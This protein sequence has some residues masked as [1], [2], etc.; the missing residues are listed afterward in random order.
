MKVGPS[1]WKTQN[2]ELVKVAIAA[3]EKRAK[4]SVKKHL[5]FGDLHTPIQTKTHPNCRY[6]GEVNK[7]GKEHG[8]GIKIWNVGEIR[9]GYFENGVDS[10]GNYI[11]ISSNGVFTV[12]E[13]YYKD[14]VRGSRGTHYRT[15]GNEEK[16]GY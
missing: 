8:R 4:I 16:Y 5:D 13:K 9:I 6:Y 3:V 14:G 12:G 10:T 11:H 15:N 2:A 7:S 1:K